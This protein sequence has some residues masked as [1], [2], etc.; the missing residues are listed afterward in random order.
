MRC[1]WGHLGCT[2]KSAFWAC[3]AGHW[4]DFGVAVVHLAEQNIF[5]NVETLYADCADYADFADWGGGVR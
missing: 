2:C 4:G 3:F 5:P 1:T